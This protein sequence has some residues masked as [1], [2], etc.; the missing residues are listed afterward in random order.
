M[1]VDLQDFLNDRVIGNVR[2]GGRGENDRPLKFNY[3]DVHVDK[4]TSEMAVEIFS[5]KYDKPKKLKIRFIKQ[6]PID[7]Y[8]ERYDGKKRRCFGNNKQAEFT[9]DNGKKQNIERDLNIIP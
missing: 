1:G 6:N 5:Q 3:F 4:T 2:S 7:V 9:D 8:L